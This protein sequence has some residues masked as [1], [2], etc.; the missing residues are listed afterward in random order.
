MNCFVTTALVNKR[1]VPGEKGFTLIELLVVVLILG[2][3]AAIAIPIYLG[4][5]ESAKE[6]AVAAQ[7]AQAKTAI[8]V[9]VVDGDSV[10]EATDKL[11]AG[12]LEGYSESETIRVTVGAP[13][14][15]VYSLTGSYAN[16]VDEDAA[17]GAD[18]WIGSNEQTIVIG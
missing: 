7:L 15:G 8:A 18:N 6:S 2:V 13:E 16:G 11:T 3:L 10:E 1:K 5:Q 4:Q 17:E 14:E 9:A 12:T